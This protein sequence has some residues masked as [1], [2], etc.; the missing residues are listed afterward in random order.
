MRIFDI[1]LIKTNVDIE[2]KESLFEMMADSL[3]R[4]GYISEKSDFLAAIRTREAA[5]S[6]GIGYG[7]AIPHGRHQCVKEMKAAVFTL[8]EDL[9]YDAL[10]GRPVRIVF[11]LAVP[12]S[13]SS[14]YM[15][16]LGSI[17]KALHNEENRSLLLA[18]NDPQ[19]IFDFLQRIDNDI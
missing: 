12:S 2:S 19:E 9:E 8:R 18:S 17:S 1:N 10:D 13:A 5:L 4:Q 7:L 6:T 15:K 11:M 14:I 16:M 3:L